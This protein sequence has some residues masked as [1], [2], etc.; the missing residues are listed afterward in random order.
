MLV[1]GGSIVAGVLPP[2]RSPSDQ[3]E[4]VDAETFHSK[5]SGKFCFCGTTVSNQGVRLE[6]RSAHARALTPTSAR[7]G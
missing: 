7:V 1:S 6:V 2:K 5:P 4:A 3:E